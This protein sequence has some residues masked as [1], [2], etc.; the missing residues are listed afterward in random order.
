MLWLRKEIMMCKDVITGEYLGKNERGMFL[1]D[2]HVGSCSPVC[3]ARLGPSAV[4]SQLNCHR[5]IQSLPAPVDK[6]DHK[7]HT[8]R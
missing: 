4:V 6:H 2:T 3:R 5:C 1:T 7:L 8:Y